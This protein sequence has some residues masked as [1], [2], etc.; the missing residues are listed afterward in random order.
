MSTGAHNMFY[1]W[2]DIAFS[3]ADPFDFAAFR[4]SAKTAGIV[5][6]FD[7]RYYHNK[8]NEIQQVM[9]KMEN[10][11]QEAYIFIV[12]RGRI[13]PQGLG[14]TIANAIHATSLDR[15]SEVYTSITGKPCKC[16]QRQDWLNN[17][18]PYVE[19]K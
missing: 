6:A 2:I 7:E 10:S 15:L 9:V 1:P 13:D 18:V 19:K 17:L 14:D 8:V 5:H 11:P 4:E 3:L 12:E 16:G